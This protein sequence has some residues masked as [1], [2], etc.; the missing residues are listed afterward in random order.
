MKPKGIRTKTYLVAV[1][2]RLDKRRS[3]GY[4]TCES[5]NELLDAVKWLIWRRKAQIISIR[6][7]EEPESEGEEA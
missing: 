6:L 5:I 2:F 3:V 1:G 7:V 4:R